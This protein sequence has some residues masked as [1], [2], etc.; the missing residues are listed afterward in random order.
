MS[1]THTELN[2]LAFDWLSRRC[3]VVISE[4]GLQ[5]GEIP[6]GLGWKANNQTILIESKFSLSDMRADAGKR[7]RRIPALGVG[8]E[9]YFLVN[10]EIAD[11]AMELLPTVWGLLVARSG[12][13]RVVRE[14][15]YFE[16]NA[17]TESKLLLSVIRRIAGR[18]EPLNGV[19]VKCFIHEWSTDTK[20]EFL[21]I[22]PD[23]VTQDTKSAIQPSAELTI[24]EAFVSRVNARAEQNMERTGKLEGSHYAAMQV[25]LKLLRE[26]APQPPATA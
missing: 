12:R 2:R 17:K 19:G 23:Q 18:P 21:S 9:R 6:D 14:S 10:A 24:I 15:G 8:G 22:M 5:G 16:H 20:K 1:Y 26:A 7:V 3:V 25:E 11:K 13:L 4:L